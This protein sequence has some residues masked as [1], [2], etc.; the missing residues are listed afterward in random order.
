M[1]RRLLTCVVT[2]ALLVAGAGCDA[3]SGGGS[4][5]QCPEADPAVVKQIMAGAR[6]DF[7]PTLPDGRPGIQIDHLEVLESGVAPLPAKD[8]KFG[9]DHLLVLLISTVLS[10][11]DASDGFQ[12]I[13]GP[14]YFALDADGKLLGPAGAFTASQFDLAS[15]KDAGWLTWGDKVEASK[16]GSELYGCVDPD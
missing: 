7:R 5:D 6:T 14:I 4:P 3:G 15:P 11:A 1:R 13:K 2:A 10:G 8:R 16:L 9:A 12:S